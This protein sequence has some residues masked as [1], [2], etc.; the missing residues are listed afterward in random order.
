M[1]NDR[2]IKTV[3][4]V[5]LERRDLREI[6][7]LR[8]RTFRDGLDL[9]TVDSELT[10]MGHM[11]ERVDPSPRTCWK[12]AK[13]LE[14]EDGRSIKLRLDSQ[15]GT[16]CES[17][18]LF[19]RPTRATACVSTQ[20]GCA[21]G[22]IFCATGKLGLRRNLTTAEIVEQIYYA[23]QRAL[24]TGRHLRNVVFMGM[25]E[26]LHNFDA[27]SA[28]LDWIKAEYGFGMSL[29]HVS[30]STIGVPN[31][32][33]ELAKRFPFVRFALSLHSTSAALRKELV[34]RANCSL[35]V[36]RETIVELNRLMPT[37]PVWLEYV[38][39]RDRNDSPEDAQSLITFCDGLNVEI[40]I[41]PYNEIGPT[42]S[43]DEAQFLVEPFVRRATFEVQESFVR[44]LRAAGIFT[45]L[46]KSLGGSIAAACGQLAGTQAR[47]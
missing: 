21:V 30:V 47:S 12:I 35:E 2:E 11:P 46:R 18:V 17:V 19:P 13:E 9:A 8:W 31:K 22:C 4:D 44:T 7:P 6:K 37:H 14:S 40:N 20:V 24:Q 43:E 45:T 39:L 15:D 42:R 38:L 10:T 41:I 28:T 16:S 32:M 26:P 3:W 1:T 34:P 5:L 23:R 29:R 33:I 36:L 25:G 27:L